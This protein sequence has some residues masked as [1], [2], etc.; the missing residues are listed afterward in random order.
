MMLAGELDATLLY[1][2]SPNLVDRSRADLWNHPDIRPLFPDPHAEGS[3]YFKKTG[4]FPINHAMIVR[5]EIAERHAWVV[6]NLF[7]C[8]ARA[9]ELVDRIRLEH[10]EYYLASGLLAPAAGEALRMPLALYG[11]A[12]NRKVLETAAAYSHEQGLTPRVMALD[13]IFAASTLE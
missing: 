10:V 2:A 5:R 1:L 3:R 12:P 11:V 9:N 8:F 4:I 6:L 13:E 7:R